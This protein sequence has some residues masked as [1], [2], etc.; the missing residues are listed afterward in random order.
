VTAART[1]NLGSSTI[2][3]TGNFDC[4]TSNNLTFNA[5]TSTINLT[6]VN[7]YFHGG[8]KTYATVNLQNSLTM[9]SNNTFGTLGL[10]AGKTYVF[11]SGST[12]IF[13]TL[14]AT[15]SAGNIITLRANIAG[16]T[17]AFSKASGTV[18]CN[19]IDVKD[20]VAGGGATFN[21]GDSSV[22]SGNNSGWT[23]PWTSGGNA[24]SSNDTYATHTS[25]TGKLYVQ[26]SKDGGTT[27]QT[28]LLKTYT[29]VEGAQTYGDGATEKWGT[30][31]TGA[32]MD[33]ASFKLRIVANST[34]SFNRHIYGGFAFDALIA[35]TRILTGVEVSV[36]AKWDGTTLSVDHIKVQGHSGTSTFPVT[37]GALAYA[38]D[39][40]ALAGYDGNNWFA[41]IPEHGWIGL[42]TC[43]YASAS[44]FTLSG[45]W[46]GILGKGDKIKLT[47]TSQKYFYVTAVSYSAP[48]TTVSV[49]AGSDYTV[50]NAAITLPYY[51]KIATPQGF[52]HW[53]T[54]APVTT[55]SAGSPTTITYTM[56]RFRMVGAATHCRTLSVD[57]NIG[58]A[59]GSRYITHPITAANTYFNV[60]GHETDISGWDAQGNGYDTSKILVLHA[61]GTTW[62]GNNMKW[63]FDWTYEI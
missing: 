13:T 18:T 11:S 48:N 50:A 56:A 24:Y 41:A 28:A 3:C 9:T 42:P 32:D 33:D 35:Q 21:P 53:F 4:Y 37:E 5:G 61:G 40:D 12:Q 30:T 27:W 16:S 46:T 52:P 60:T 2:T 34:D 14:T 25:P 44:T 22:D 6:G 57:T 51:A 63:Y 31:F 26:L 19:F 43:T 59:S 49:F 36:E 54:W 45:D 1:I 29:G 7:T 47:Q 10:T 38:T 55:S 17:F 15:G 23:Q 20:C 58:T 8:A 39:K 62:N